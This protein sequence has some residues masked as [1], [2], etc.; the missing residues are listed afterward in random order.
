MDGTNLTRIEQFTDLQ[1]IFDYDLT[2]T[3]YTVTAA[4]SSLGF[5]NR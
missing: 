1:V 5:T 4:L 3:F 2:F